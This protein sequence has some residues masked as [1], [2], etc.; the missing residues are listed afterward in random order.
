MRFICVEPLPTHLGRPMLATSYQLCTDCGSSQRT[1][2]QFVL[3][4]CSSTR[5]P[6]EGR[7]AC[8]AMLLYEIPSAPSTN[9]PTRFNNRNSKQQRIPQTRHTA[10]SHFNSRMRKCAMHHS[11]ALAA[12]F[13]LLKPTTGTQH[14]ATQS[15]QPTTARHA[16][17]AQ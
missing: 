13:P 7:S 4:A 15:S 5:G 16:D 17:H 2:D 14:T 8:G 1:T 6:L 10:V 3:H 9:M 12:L 11:C